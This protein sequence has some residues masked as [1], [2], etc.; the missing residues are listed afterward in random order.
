MGK[1][2]VYKI[3]DKEGNLS[4]G[5]TEA[6]SKAEVVSK[7]RRKGYYVTS[8]EQQNSSME[9]NLNF[10]KWKKIGLSDLAVFARQFST[11]VGSGISLVRALNIL[12]GQSSNL[13]LSQAVT[14]V[15]DKVESG[16]PLSQAMEEEGVFP[17]L[18]I[19][20]IAAGE[21]GGNLDLVLE[22]MATHFEHESELQKKINSALA[23]PIIILV[24]AVAVMVFLIMGVLPT[25][26]DM[27]SDMGVELPL[28]T[29]IILN[30]GDHAPLYLG[31]GAIIIVAIIGILYAYRQTRQGRRNLD[32]LLLKLP[33]IG[34]LQTKLA[35]VRFS[36]TLGILVGSGV[37]ILESLEIVSK[38]ISNR[39]ISD[40]I[41]EARK[42]I[43]EGESI[44]LP[45][46]KNDIFPRM[47]LQMI[48]I[49][50]E[51]GNIEEMLLKVAD[52]YKKESESK[53]DVL[54]SLIE[55]ALILFLGLV[56]GGIVIS[57]MLPMFNMIQYM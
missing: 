50:E 20:M 52:F 56:V 54:V 36:N 9:I 27:F 30:L 21:A 16:I 48:R 3:R 7:L 57:I 42:S 8:V 39:V 28:I 26:V 51:T 5:L 11:M 19:S 15:R 29:R 18:F 35:V 17:K 31:I 2:F 34:D 13:K 40:S 37:S 10:D 6:E 24:V 32:A 14:T 12:E 22:E 1:S 45:L 49:G 55:P 47:V 4:K 53:I 23:Y 41:V 44:A 43:S 25:F 33:L 38:V 46:S